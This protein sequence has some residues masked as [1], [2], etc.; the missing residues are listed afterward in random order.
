MPVRIPDDNVAAQSNLLPSPG[1]APRGLERLATVCLRADA[2]DSRLGDLSEQY[3]RIYAR[4]RDYLGNAPLAGPV[5]HLAA[6]MR[7]L[8]SAANVILF[9]RAVDPGLRLAE[10]E[11]RGT[12]ALDLRERTMRM[13]HTT[14]QKLVLP[15]LLLA[16]SAFLIHGAVSVWN[17]WRETEVL[18]VDLQRE[19][20]EAAATQIG[21]YIATVQGQIA[22][23]AV[24]AASP[25]Q[26]RYD[27]LRLLRHVPAIVEISDLNAEGKEVRKVSRLGKD[28][29]DS[30]IDFSADVRFTEA[31]KRN[32]YIGPVYFD[33]QSVPHVSIAIAHAVP[34]AGATLAEVNI[35]RLW[36]IIDTIKV[37]ETGYAYL[38][39]GKGR[40][41]ASR[42]KA[43]VG[44]QSD[45]STMPQ[46]AAAFGAVPSEAPVAGKTYASS[47][48]GSA[49]LSVHAAV[50]SLAWKVFVELP[51]AE[52]RAPLWST[53]FR[54]ATLLGLGLLA[55]F[56]A[57]LAA[58]RRDMT[59]Q[60]AR[61]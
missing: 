42:D 39:D 48:A 20:A 55:I 49:V 12:F 5:S 11:T 15:A 18:L 3:V 26:R 6:D 14:T 59:P 31:V 13:L 8:F 61:T 1:R 36:D 56:L 47:I 51:V 43:R 57:S 54:A 41:I 60:P 52:A 21:Q 7:Y 46:V 53:V 40:V 10:P 9:A 33:K 44:P 45:L 27:Y 37:G 23:A 32:K 29:V 17:T 50:P 30:G 24:P 16:G 19:K 58:A 38:V 2:E 35:K 25:E 34:N 28:T 4:V 22:W